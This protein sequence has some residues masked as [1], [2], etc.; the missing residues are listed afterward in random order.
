M[1]LFVL[2]TCSFLTLWGMQEAPHYYNGTIINAQTIVQLAPQ[3]PTDILDHVQTWLSNNKSLV[4]AALGYEALIG[5]MKP[6]HD[7]TNGVLTQLGSPNKSPYN[8]VFDVPQSQLIM[9]IAGH[10]NRKYNLMVMAE[11]LKYPND[12]F[13]AEHYNYSRQLTTGDFNLFGQNLNDN[14]FDVLNS[15]IGY[16]APAT[17]LLSH[18]DYQKMQE[19][20]L[21]TAQTGSP[22]Y[23]APKT[24]QTISRMAYYLL[25][26]DAQQRVGFNHIVAPQMHLIHIPSRPEI[27]SDRNY[28]IVEKKIH[29]LQ[30]LGAVS[31]EEKKE[32]HNVVE[33]TGLFNLTK[34]NVMRTEKG[35]IVV[36]DWEQPNNSNPRH[37]FHKAYDRFENNMNA[38]KIHLMKIF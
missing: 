18:P 16:T 20:L 34:D 11:Y 19:R 21:A 33:A 27:V 6:F 10:C 4:S 15:S 29:N 24:Y 8:Y 28:V 37:F 23:S 9:K 12:S 38:G 17:E 1:K 14:E 35:K 7:K 30:P 25:F 26:L 36:L 13:N 5:S 31:D 22:R 2:I 3:A 32:L